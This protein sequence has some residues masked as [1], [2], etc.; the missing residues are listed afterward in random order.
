MKTLRTVTCLTEARAEKFLAEVRMLDR[1]AYMYRLDDDETGWY[2]ICY[3]W[4]A[5]RPAPAV[6]KVGN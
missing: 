6:P 2:R 3:Y 5:T 4:D 1:T